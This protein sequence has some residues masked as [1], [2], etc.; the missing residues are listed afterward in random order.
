MFARS[1]SSSVG[2]A[3]GCRPEYPVHAEG[4]A[5]GPGSAVGSDE[6]SDVRYAP[7]EARLSRGESAPRTQRA[8][9]GAGIVG[10]RSGTLRPVLHKAESLRPSPTATTTSRSAACG[11]QE[12]AKPR[13]SARG[14]RKSTPARSIRH[15]TRANQG[16]A[17]HPFALRRIAVATALRDVR[18]WRRHRRVLPRRWSSGAAG[19]AGQADRVGAVDRSFGRRLSVVGALA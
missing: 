15:Q 4:V 12:A 6:W 17:W 3:S 18:S 11:W 13:G 14:C 1:R 8:T 19:L 7:Q 10:L 5:R 9:A 2:G 16:R